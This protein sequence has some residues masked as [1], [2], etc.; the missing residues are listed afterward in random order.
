MWAKH[1]LSLNVNG[2]HTVISHSTNMIAEEYLHKSPKQS[3]ST[4]DLAIP[5]TPMIIRVAVPS[6]S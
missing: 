6:R 5:E 2:L 1:G 4:G 3:L